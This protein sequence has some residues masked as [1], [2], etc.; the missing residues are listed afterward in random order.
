VEHA[1][2]ELATSAMPSRPFHSL[3]CTTQP[4]GRARG[5]LDRPQSDGLGDGLPDEL[6]R[7]EG[8]EY[9]P[10]WHDAASAIFA[11]PQRRAT[12]ART[13]R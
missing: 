7:D 8:M 10:Y 12:S 6:R 4:L 2:I 11:T 13:E 9:V 3:H 1:R 5:R